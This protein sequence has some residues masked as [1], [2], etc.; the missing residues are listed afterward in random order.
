M[1]LLMAVV[2]GSQ[3]HE[4]NDGHPMFN[5][6]NFTVLDQERLDA[7]E[8]INQSELVVRG[9]I[10]KVTPG[11]DLFIEGRLSRRPISFSLFKV[12]VTQAIKGSVS[13]GDYVYFEWITGGISAYE[14]DAKKYT[15]EI[16]LMLRKTS[17]LE[18]NYSRV[19]NRTDGL[20][21]EVD[22]LYEL[23]TPRALFVQD[24]SKGKLERPLDSSKSEPLFNAE[25]FNELENFF[26]GSTSAFGS[27][28]QKPKKVER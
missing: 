27:R 18:E 4:S 23:T 28:V 12:R 21:Y 1:F 2:F 8:A 15:D 7:F 5:L 9:V 26:D 17:F 13:P 11:R 3:A 20:M 10:E 16:M 24:K 14:L 25:S 22:T 19:E 6:M